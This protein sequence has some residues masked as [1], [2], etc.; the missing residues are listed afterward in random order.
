[1]LGRKLMCVAQHRCSNTLT[2]VRFGKKCP[3]NV[4]LTSFNQL[5]MTNTSVNGLRMPV[6]SSCPWCKVQFPR[7]GIQFNTKS[8]VEMT[9]QNKHDIHYPPRNSIP[10]F[11]QNVL[12]STGCYI[13]VVRRKSTWVP[14]R[15]KIRKSAF[16]ENVYANRTCVV[17][18]LRGRMFDD[19]TW[20]PFPRI[21]QFSLLKEQ[22]PQNLVSAQFLTS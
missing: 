22:W 11:R 8:Y 17:E 16:W 1:M 13:G 12:W 10:H 6:S 9:M 5:C 15:P 18:G 3:W 20:C 4:L 21:I 7:V 2:M 14:K 19:A